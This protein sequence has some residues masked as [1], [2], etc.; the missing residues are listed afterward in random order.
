[1]LRADAG[2]G[3]TGTVMLRAD[4]GGGRTGTVVLHAGAV[5]GR[6]GTVVLHAGAGW[7]PY[8][9]A[10]R[11]GPGRA[12]PDLARR[13]PRAGGRLVGTVVL[14]AGAAGGRSGTV[15]L[16]ADADG[17]RTGTVMLRAHAGGGRTGTVVLRTPVR[18]GSRTGG[19]T[20]TDQDERLP[21]WHVVR[22]APAAG[23]WAQWCC[24]PARLAAAPARWPVRAASA[25]AGRA[26]CRCGWL[27]RRRG[28][29]RAGTGG[30]CR[31]VVQLRVGA[32]GAPA[33]GGAGR[34]GPPRSVLVPGRVNS[35]RVVLGRA[36][37]VVAVPAPARR[38]RTGGR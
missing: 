34:A 2:G 27:S 13:A 33:P 22:R 17:G 19:Q 12:A 26:A 37:A 36:G 30:P 16:R 20:V 4:A 35:P 7:L 32:G 6:T 23:S 1:M 11:H 24:T 15:V 18:G 8:R 25:P 14:H 38:V 9:R 28:A 5:G 31:R 29:L 10:D 3:R 21:T